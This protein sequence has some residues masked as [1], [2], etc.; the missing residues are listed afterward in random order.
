MDTSE[1]IIKLIKESTADNLDLR[2]K[3]YKIADDI[4]DNAT[5]EED[6]Y[7]RFVSAVKGLYPNEFM[8][9][10]PMQK[11]LDD[12]GATKASVGSDVVEG[13]LVPSY[14]QL[15]KALD[16][17]I[18]NLFNYD[19]GELGWQDMPGDVLKRKLARSGIDFITGL[20]T[21][22]DGQ[23]KRDR[24][25]I[26]EGYDPRT[27]DIDPIGWLESAYMGVFAPRQKKAYTEGRDPEFKDYLGDA[28]ANILQSVPY[29]RAL[30]MA[31]KIPT[32]ARGV[33]A[34]GKTSPYVG[35]A[36]K[37][38]KTVAENA[39]APTAE[40]IYDMGAYDESLLDAGLKSGFG[41]A[42][43]FGTPR[44]I[45]ALASKA[46]STLEGFGRGGAKQASRKV[47]EFFSDPISENIAA[48]ERAK[49]IATRGAAPV[50]TGAGV[51]N[52]S[53]WAT[54]AEYD[55]AL[56]VLLID[57]MKKAGFFKTKSK[58]EREKI[59]SDYLA[60][61]AND[62]YRQGVLKKISEVGIDGIT[63]IERFN[64]GVP[65]ETLTAAAGE[66]ASLYGLTPEGKIGKVREGTGFAK[67]VLDPEEHAKNVAFKERHGYDPEMRT[68]SKSASELMEEANEKI[69]RDFAYPSD[70]DKT[71]EKLL[72]SD[73]ELASIALKGTE[74]SAA[75]LGR[76]SGLGLLTNKL[77]RE[78]YASSVP[79]VSDLQRIKD[80][81]EAK[82]MEKKRKQDIDKAAK[83]EAEKEYQ[84][85]LDSIIETTSDQWE[86]GFTPSP[87]DGDIYYEAWK[88]WKNK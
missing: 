85:E 76:V 48:L 8:D 78:K 44:A 33:Q 6:Q 65:E 25:M 31:G 24:A 60:A 56:D 43:N 50:G 70:F 42:V 3:L 87:V 55:K 67:D 58:K 69:E 49:D 10:S 82:E 39:I 77:G 26:M 15:A 81:K 68:A 57:E 35:T 18:E 20:N 36:M 14:A 38:A 7:L 22:S 59:V 21:L 79:G 32:I 19:N 9:D 61:H 27:G 41:T 51:L 53:D 84:A 37:G 72:E 28:G 16:I 86:A 17:P 74:N 47:E 71:L 23:I 75:D 29:G 45:K 62:E 5:S 2:K 11:A 46:G 40:A 52:P 13:K 73:P 34:L 1:K 88:K 30:G 12:I 64:R 54:F 4:S 63:Q 66:A 80:E 83:R